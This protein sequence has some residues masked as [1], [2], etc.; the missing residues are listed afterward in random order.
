MK[1]L[2]F[3][4]G[5]LINLSMNG[6]LY[7]VESLRKDFKGKFLITKE[8]KNEV[9]DRPKG[10][11]RFELGALSIEGLLK[12]G[13]IE[14]P[15]SFEIDSKSLDKKTDEFMSNANHFVKVESRWISLVSSAE[16]SCLALS[17]ELSER[18]I[19]NVISIDERTTRILCEDPR[20]LEKLMSE[21]LHQRVEIAGDIKIF[22]NFR[23]IRSAELVFAAY[24]KGFVKITGSKVLEALLYATKF[25]GCAIS[26]DEIEEMKKL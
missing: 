6:L 22:L 1:A 23:F 7:L 18:D 17:S 25:K 21:R 4:S 14:M 19:E 12:D 26:Y 20:Q 5:A 24:K 2:I 16:M 8:V 10:I 13:I 15:E 9:I 11:P 3:D